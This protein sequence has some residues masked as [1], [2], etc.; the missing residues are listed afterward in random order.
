MLNKFHKVLF[1]YFQFII[2]YFLYIIMP[3]YKIQSNLLLLN[4][5]LFIFIFI[6][7]FKIIILILNFIKEIYFISNLILTY[8]YY[9][10][11]LL[12]HHLYSYFSYKN[13]FLIKY[14]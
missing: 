12:L 9:S 6:L 10:I 1:H 2:S 7:I 11:I 4:L 14:I 5:I 3:I 8:L 13:I